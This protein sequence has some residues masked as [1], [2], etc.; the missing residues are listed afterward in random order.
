MSFGSCVYLSLGIFV[1]A[2]CAAAQDAPAPHLNARELFYNTASAQPAAPN[3]AAQAKPVTQANSNTKR[4]RPAAPAKKAAST[5][6]P[7]ETAQNTAP[8]PPAPAV[9]PARPQSA[10]PA[11]ASGGAAVIPVSFSS[12][13]APSTPAA[14]ALGLKYIITKMV[15]NQQVEVAPD[16]VFHAGDRI[17]FAVEPNGPGYLYIIRQGSSGTWEPVFPSPEISDSNNRVDG[18]RSYMMPPKSRLVFDQQTGTEK[19][20]IVLSRNE[21]PDLEQLMYSLRN[22]AKPVSTPQTQPKPAAKTLVAGLQI[23]NATV[24]RLRNTYARDLI[25][26]KVD[27]DTPGDRKEKAVYVVNPTGSRESSVVADIELVHQ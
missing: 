5:P 4:P 25:I 6:P 13:P 24:G 26:E 20:F 3:S 15:G 11:K 16:T 2:A 9:A 18:W 14:P 23:D 27:E 10:P 12:E 19:I 17:R 1:G 8:A 21:V 22:G 7:V